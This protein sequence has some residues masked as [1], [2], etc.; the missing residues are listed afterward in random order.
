MSF[1]RKFGHSSKKKIERTIEPVSTFLKANKNNAVAPSVN[2]VIDKPMF[3][4]GGEQEPYDQGQLGSCTA[5]ALAFAFVYNVVRNGYRP[6]MPSRLDIYYNERLHMGGEAELEY[7]NGANISDCEYV[8]E[9]V[10][11]IPEKAWPYTDDSNNLLYYVIPETVNN[12]VRT[13]ALSHNTMYYIDP[14]NLNNIKLVLTN[15]YPLVCGI[16]VDID[17]FSSQ[18]T[19]CTGIITKIPN[20]KRGRLGGHAIVIVGYTADGYFLIRNSWGVN[21]G[22]GFLNQ[23]TG[24]YNYDEYEGK[25]RGYF[26]VPF[27]YITN[28]DITS[29]MYVVTD[30]NDTIKTLNSGPF[31][32]SQYFDSSF[33]KETVIKPIGTLYKILEIPSAKLKVEIYYNY[34]S[35]T[36][37]YV[38]NLR[39]T[40]LVGVTF[41]VLNECEITNLNYSNEFVQVG[42]FNK[43]KIVSSYVAGSSIAI[44]A[45]NKIA[46]I[47]S[48]NTA[49]GKMS[50]ISSYKI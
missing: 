21:W 27:S 18:N 9:N 5:N 7:D 2:L 37:K 25:M 30:M 29:E 13:L 8:L 45:N 14:T 46:D 6:F 31:S 20:L 15:G 35:L 38:W 19:A 42:F 1:E 17:V 47:I 32:L 39:C 28:R 49:T 48:I 23:N 36:S 26:K 12:E 4:I 50:I 22:L 11:L 24:I 40:R 43:S 44:G 3:L 41:Q 10:G 34:N 33:N 16:L